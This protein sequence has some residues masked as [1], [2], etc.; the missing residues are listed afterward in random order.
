M[1][2][3]DFMMLSELQKSL[4]ALV[5]RMMA[6]GYSQTVI[7]QTLYVFLVAKK[8]LREGA[9]LRVNK[10]LDA[11][12]KEEDF[13]HEMSSYCVEIMNHHTPEELKEAI[14]LRKKQREQR[15]H[16]TE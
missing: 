15:N 2:N 6:M 10:M 14:E 1:G 7:E 13:W 9:V 4:I 12:P 11:S 8:E 5:N 16:K 3:E